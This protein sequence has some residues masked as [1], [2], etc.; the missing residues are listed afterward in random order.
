MN[1]KELEERVSL[2]ELVKR[3]YEVKPIS[4]NQY[5]VNPC[6][7]CG[8]NDHFTIYADTNSYSSFNGCCVGGSVY[9]YLQEVKGL[10][11]EEAY[12]ELKKLTNYEQSLEQKT[13][14]E[15]IKVNKDYTE[16]INKFYNNQTEEQ[17][18]YFKNRGLSEDIIKK[19]KLCVEGD[20]A[21]VPFWN[22]GK[23][24]YYIQRAIND[25]QPKYKNLQ[26]LPVPIWNEHYLED[27]KEPT[28][29]KEPIIVCEGIFDALSV[30]DLGFK[31]ISINGVNNTN[32]LLSELDKKQ[33]FLLTAFD[34]DEAGRDATN[35][36][37]QKI[38][39]AR[40]IP[41]PQDF[42][43]INEWYTA[44]KEGILQVINKVIK[45]HTKPDVVSIYL[46][47]FFKEDILNNQKACL[48][49]TGFKN[50][51]KNL[52][53]LY[54]GLYVLGGATSL[55]K[56]TFAHQIAD[57]LAEQGEDVIYFTL[58][59][60]RLELVSKSLSRLTA[61]KDI[62]NAITSLQIRSGYQLDSKERLA[63]LMNAVREYKQPSEHISIIEGNYNLTIEG[64]R[65]YID[66][67]IKANKV[68]P[69]VFI[70]YLQV[71]QTSKPYLAS[72]KQRI[73]YIITELK[74]ISRDFDITLFVISSI[75]RSGYSKPIDLVAPKESGGIEYTADVVLGLQLDVKNFEAEEINKA[76]NRNPRPIKLVCLKNRYGACFECLFDYQPKFDLFEVS[77][78]PLF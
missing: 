71:L 61:K 70:D 51:D 30:E 22:K 9:K 42:K 67:Y 77:K 28:D 13:K 1:V 36:V 78:K 7:V 12:S 49:K 31:A 4:N 40:Q 27:A 24:I 55:G 76:K 62:N 54:N 59:Q 57:Q 75:N 3:D 44:D 6:P 64:I 20:Y 72:D 45:H 33:I 56:T 11:E 53:G 8:H 69:F 10:S 26:D 46:E 16:Q 41:I 19:Y 38:T 25:T 34:N 2:L 66:T 14:Q 68:K 39:S 58:E 5:R 74:R 35:K 43:D 18:Q 29:T 48:K 17:K 21:T 15:V 23:V 63:L 47:E 52:Q 50:L 37:L 60:S 65:Q 32:K 73:D